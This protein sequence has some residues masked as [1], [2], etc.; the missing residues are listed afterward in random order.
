MSNVILDSIV[1][2]HEFTVEDLGYNK[3]L[4][5]CSDTGELMAEVHGTKE[6]YSVRFHGKRWAEVKAEIDAIAAAAPGLFN[7]EEDIG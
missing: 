7:D 6:D 4:Y 1:G 3:R 2:N 5:R